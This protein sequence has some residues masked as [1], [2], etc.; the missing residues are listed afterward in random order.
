[1][2][3]ADAGVG[4]TGVVGARTGAFFDVDETLIPV[5][6]MFDFLAFR[7]AELGR[8]PSAYAESAAE[9]RELAASGVPREEI[10]REYYRLYRGASEQELMASGRRWFATR[11][12]VPGFFLEG[13]VLALRGHLADGAHVVLLSGSFAPCLEPLAR[14]LGATAFRGTRPLVADGRLTGEVERP[15]I[16]PAKGEAVH[17][18]AQQ[19]GL[20][21]AWSHAYGDHISDLPM[22]EAVGHPHVRADGDPALL[23]HASQRGWPRVHDPAPATP[24]GDH[25]SE[26]VCGCALAR[27]AAPSNHPTTLTTTGDRA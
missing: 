13:S 22:L 19:H 23:G 10:N 8:P 17:E 26:C 24:S 2:V 4:G 5:K 12:A 6:S 9:L 27:W 21:P 11:A 20:D 14:A 1:M 15:M 7:L 18:Y 3:G 16:G 25:G